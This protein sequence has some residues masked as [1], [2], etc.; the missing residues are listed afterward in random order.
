MAFNAA[1]Y[2]AANP[3]VKA[4]G[5]DPLEHFNTFGKAEGR[6]GTG[7]P[8]GFDPQAYLSANQDVAAAGANPFEHYATYGKNE[9]RKLAVGTPTGFDPIGYLAQNPDVN[10]FIKANPGSTSAEKHWNQF[11]ANEG[12]RW[13]APV[14]APTQPT[15]T[16]FDM[17]EFFRRLQGMNQGGGNNMLQ[18]QTDAQAA[19]DRSNSRSKLFSNILRSRSRGPSRAFTMNSSAAPNRG[20]F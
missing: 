1:A 19:V 13:S 2:L 15:N 14:A 17:D 10:N 4:A 9:N 12:R 6:S 18:Q 20:L 11:G 8:V 16:T 3:D 5:V 7:T